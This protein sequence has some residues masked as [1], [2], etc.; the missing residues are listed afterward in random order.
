MR[1]AILSDVHG[2]LVALEAVLA[3]LAAEAVDQVV[4]LGDACL[5]GPEPAACVQ[6]LRALGGPA[7]QGNT[8][9]WLLGAGPEPVQSDDDQRRLDIMLWNAAALSSEDRAWLSSLAP[10]AALEL[11]GSQRLVACHGSPQSFV[12]SITPA[13]P[14]ADLERMVAGAEPALVA[15]GHTHQALLR[16]WRRVRFINPGSVGLAPESQANLRRPT[17]WAEYAVIDATAA[18]LNV[19]FRRQGFEFEALA[20]A[21]RASG[22]PH[23]DWWL[24]QWAPV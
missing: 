3:R 16:R 13:T 17:P 10:T 24:A 6:R 21:A 18:G 14:E 19:E 4:F 8:D 20:R 7:I 1:L 15:A 2:N 9:H 5:L 22:M 23:A 11:P 12:E